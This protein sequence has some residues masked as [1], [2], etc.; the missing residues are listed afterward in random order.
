MKEKL[1]SV[2]LKMADF[3]FT[4]QKEISVLTGIALRVVR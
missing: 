2:R 3:L 1:I 4:G